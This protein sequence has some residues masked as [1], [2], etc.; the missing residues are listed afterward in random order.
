M[1]LHILAPLLLVA[2]DSPS[3]QMRGA[4]A[5][6]F[7][8]EGHSMTLWRDDAQVEVIRHGYATR[9]TQPRLRAAMAR[10][11]VDLTGCELRPGTLQ[12]DTGVMRAE[13]DCP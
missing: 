13:L 9:E 12:G 2:C 8:A 10:A 7:R 4:Q 3:P 5:I 6:P 11:I 1:R